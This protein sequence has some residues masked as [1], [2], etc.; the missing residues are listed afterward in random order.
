MALALVAPGL[1]GGRWEWRLV[2][3]WKGTRRSLLVG[4]GGSG[5]WCLNGRDAA[6]LLVVV[7]GV[8]AAREVT[9]EAF[10]G[11][12]WHW[13]ARLVLLSFV[14]ILYRRYLKYVVL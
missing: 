6:R 9:R 4:G 13:R 1:C 11:H 7:D 10:G 5:G 8:C 2:F 14:Y 12:G 3:E